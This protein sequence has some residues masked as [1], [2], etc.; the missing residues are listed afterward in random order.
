MKAVVIVGTGGAETLE[1]RDVPRPDPQGDEVLVRVRACGINRADLMQ[2][3]GH[4]PAPPGAPSDIPGLE[5][6]GE[7]EALGPRCTGL[8]KEGSRVFGIVG[9]GGMAEYL[10]T[11]ERMLAPIAVNLDFIS[12]AAVPE[13]FITAHDALEARAEL[14]PGQ[15][16]LIHAV[17]GGVGSAAVQ[18]AHA[19][20]CF[21][22]GTSRTGE[23]LAKCVEYGL[24]VGI[25]SSRES[26]ADV[27]AER[28]GGVGVQA[29]IDHIGAPAWT[30]NVAALAPKGCLVL[31]GLLGGSKASVDLSALLR[32]RLRIVATTLRA[33]PLEEKITATRRFAEQVVP[34]LERG[35]VRPIVD[36][37]YPLED[38]ASAQIRLESDLG[39]GK[40]VLET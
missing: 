14:R 20:G 9:G 22:L 28:T 38:V 23:K 12:A 16:V 3:R 11:P 4:Y 18:I 19:M 6:A 2:A 39:F 17:G 7:V 33:R 21:V 40:I 29:V 15:S 31:V 26:F 35:L 8:Y 34:W 30:G 5:F 36:R 25:D 13:V 27:V 37:V 10:V 1:V 32:K 24:D